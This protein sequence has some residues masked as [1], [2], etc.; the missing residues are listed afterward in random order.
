[1]IRS[2][3]LGA[4]G[5]QNHQLRMDVVGNNISNINT[6]A[7]KTNR[8]N[9]QDALYQAMGTGNIRNH[10]VGTGVNIGA[11]SGNFTQGAL[12]NTGRSL[13]IAIQGN[14][15]FGLLDPH[16]DSNEIKFTRDGAFYIDK[17]GYLV[18]SAGLR[19]VNTSGNEIEIELVDGQSL[20]DISIN[21]LGKIYLSGVDL[22]EQIGLFYFQ[23]VNGLTRIG[24]NLFLENDTTGDR[25]EGEP[26]SDNFGIIRA[27]FLEMSNIDVVEELAAL[28]STQRG[29]QMNAKVFVTADEVLQDIIQLKR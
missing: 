16:G 22:N 21:K 14:G 11:V 17:E 15:F 10:Q 24:N 26:G 23:N 13:D 19:L 27:G 18:N 9:F 3:Y 2:M 28:I 29:Y 6:T 4:S 25:Q 5:M 1:M 12:Q 8:A 20:E 7:Y